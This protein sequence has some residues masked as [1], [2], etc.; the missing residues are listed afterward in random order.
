M[1]PTQRT[2]KMAKKKK[3]TTTTDFQENI[4]TLDY[5]PE[6]CLDWE[7]EYLWTL[8][9]DYNAQ[10]ERLEKLVQNILSTPVSERSKRGRKLTKDELKDKQEQWEAKYQ[11]FLKNEYQQ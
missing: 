8:Q 9:T 3:P 11:E 6:A 2:K 10:T 7:D 5:I 4:V 1:N